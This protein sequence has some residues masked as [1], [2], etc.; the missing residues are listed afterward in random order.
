VIDDGLL[1]AQRFEIE[2]HVV[3]KVD[4]GVGFLLHCQHLAP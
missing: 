3:Q 1:L 2:P 4:D